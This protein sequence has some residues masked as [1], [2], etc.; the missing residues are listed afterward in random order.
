[1]SLRLYRFI[2][3]STDALQ[4]Y[5][6]SQG[7]CSDNEINN[8]Q[9]SCKQR[10]INKMALSGFGWVGLIAGVF[11]ITKFKTSCKLVLR[12]SLCIQSVSFSD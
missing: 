5:E 6:V 3:L 2:Q 8:K 11:D 1:M 10:K 9:I 4:L 7:F 12:L